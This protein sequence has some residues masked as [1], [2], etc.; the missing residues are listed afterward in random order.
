[1]KET[2]YVGLS[3]FQEF[4]KDLDEHYVVVGGFATLMLLDN[5]IANHGKATYDIDLVLLSSNSKEI[6]QRIKQYVKEGEYKIQT[7]STDQYQYW[8]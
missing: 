5:E 1:M 2:D 7:G 6:T 4:C 3:H 8:V